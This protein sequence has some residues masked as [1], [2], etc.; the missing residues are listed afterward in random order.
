[1]G[2]ENYTQLVKK[3][4][5]RN[6]Y[7]TLATSSLNGK[8]EAAIMLYAEENNGNLYFYTFVDSRKY[9]NLKKNPCVSM[10]VYNHPDY[11][12]MDGVAKEL[13]KKDSIVAKTKLITK[14]GDKK[15]YHADPRCRYFCFTP[16]WINVRIDEN[17]PAKYI[18]IKK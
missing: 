15:G 7:C 16:K 8:P 13:S 14:H 12:Q 11:I 1:M 4:L 18:V 17:Y 6:K 2:E 10:V 3:I 5:K 9:A